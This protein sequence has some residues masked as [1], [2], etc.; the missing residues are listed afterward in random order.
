MTK[1]FTSD[2]PSIDEIL[3]LK[4]PREVSVDIFIDADLGREIMQLLVEIEQ[5]KLQPQSKTKGLSEKPMQAKIEEKQEEVNRAIEDAEVATFVF[6]DIGRL[7]YDTLLRNSPPTDQD[8]EDWE[9]N[10]NQGRAPFSEDAFVPGLIAACSA[11]PEI[12]LEQAVE[13]YN[14][15]GRTEVELLFTAAMQACTERADIPLFRIASELM[16]SSPSK[17]NTVSSEE[18]PEANS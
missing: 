13:I 6:R 10:G 2:S 17:S 11:S 16:K 7:K 3:R 14:T 9:R 8:Q 1:K 18:S 12:P 5:M 15:W 4:K